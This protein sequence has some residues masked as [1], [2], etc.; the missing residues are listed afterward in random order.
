MTELKRRH[1]IVVAA[2]IERGDELLVSFRHPKGPRPSKWEFPGG[3]VEPGETEPDALIREMKEELGVTV[4][5]GESI[6]RLVH[7]YP[8]TDVEISFYRARIVEG[9]PQP[10]EMEEIRWV[11]RADLGQLDFLEADRPFVGELLSG[12]IR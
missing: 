1:M 3:K 8:D 10:L 12:A 4:E 9:T 7:P 5:V 6:K 2:V 11:R